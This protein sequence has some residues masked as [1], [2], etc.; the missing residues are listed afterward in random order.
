[1]VRMMG[2]RLAIIRLCICLEMASMVSLIVTDY[3]KMSFTKLGVHSV[4]L[5][6]SHG[7]R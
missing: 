1:M 4:S 6:L 2:N 5:G 7:H 3:V